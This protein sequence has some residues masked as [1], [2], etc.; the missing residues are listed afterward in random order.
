MKHASTPLFS[1]TLSLL[2]LLPTISAHGLITS[3]TPR[4]PGPALGSACGT[5]ILAQQSS[6]PYGNIQG[7]TQVLDSTFDASACNLWL[8]KGYQLADNTANIQ[9]YTPGETVA[10]TVEIRA[11]HTGVANVSIVDTAT[12]TV[13][14]GPL[15][16]WEEYAS[17]SAS[18][19][20]D[21]TEFEVTIPEDLGGKCAVAG[22][23]VLQWFWDAR[24][25][26]QT[27]EACVDFIIDGGGSKGGDDGEVVPTTSINTGVQIPSQTASTTAEPSGTS[28]V[29]GVL[30]TF[31]TAPAEFGGVQYV[32]RVEE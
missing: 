19:P 13:E 2:S 5:Q 22:E 18:I 1:L 10:V 7:E 27:Y 9:T 29:S 15:I 8:C 26:D 32:C 23:C 31:T 6:D 21:Q 20:V 14:S 11:P 28:E 24:S 16:S 17:N 4:G 30:P 25:V 3:P 12:N